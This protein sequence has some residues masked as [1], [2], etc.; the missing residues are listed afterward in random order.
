MERNNKEF[1]RI[2]TGNPLRDLFFNY[3]LKIDGLRDS[4]DREELQKTLDIIIGLLPSNV[5]SFCVPIYREEET[6]RGIKLLNNVINLLPEN[7]KSLF[8]FCYIF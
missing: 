8:L 2:D 1:N 7:V 3:Y 4:E 5:T 6:K